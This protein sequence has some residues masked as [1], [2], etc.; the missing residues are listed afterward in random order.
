MKLLLRLFLLICLLF[1][2][3]VVLLWP[4]RSG[5]LELGIEKWIVQTQKELF[6]GRVDVEGLELKSNLF[7]T[8]QS[9]RGVWQTPEGGFPFELNEIEVNAPITYF[10]RGKPV[11]VIF[12][13][14]RPADSEHPGVS[15]IMTLHNDTNETFELKADF[16]GLHLEELAPFNPEVLTKSSGNLTGNLFIKA[17]KSGSETIRLNLNVTEPGGRLPAY[18]FDSLLPYLPPAEKEALAKIQSLQ[19]VN[20]QSAAISVELAEKDALKVLLRIRVPDYNLN[21]NLNLTI[22]VEDNT[23]FFELAQLMGLIKVGV[24]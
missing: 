9:I 20:Y 24:T 12:K 7:V 10:F 6:V 14:F 22:R 4:K 23:A 8:I 15:G 5:L 1:V 11:N 19:S 3:M 21:L 17:H 16:Y 2:L 13:Q 18:F